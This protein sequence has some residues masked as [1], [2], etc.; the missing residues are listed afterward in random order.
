MINLPL[1][2]SC[3]PRTIQHRAAQNIYTLLW[4]NSNIIRGQLWY[5]ANHT[6]KIAINNTNIRKQQLNQKRTPHNGVLFA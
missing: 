4:H 1:I 6:E 5:S 3:L 2:L